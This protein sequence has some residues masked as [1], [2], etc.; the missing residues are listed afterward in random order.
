MR[1]C[2]SAR[3]TAPRWRTRACALRRRSS[4]PW[5]ITSTRPPGKRSSAS[6]SV[7]TPFSAISRPTY[8]PPLR[9]R[10]GRMM[11]LTAIGT[12]AS[13]AVLDA[14]GLRRARRRLLFRQVLPLGQGGDADRLALH[15]RLGLLRG[16][17][18]LSAQ[19]ARRIQVARRGCCS[20]PWLSP[21][22]FL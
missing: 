5:P 12:P 19:T 11:A 13:R 6:S 15:L 16:F 22:F 2:S 20:T 1:S 14:H 18:V 8:R 4:A 9:A 10:V 21:L 7:P 17:L 3:L